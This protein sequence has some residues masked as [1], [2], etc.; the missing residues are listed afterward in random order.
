VQTLRLVGHEGA[1]GGP[2]GERDSGVLATSACLS[3][4]RLLVG[5]SA[6]YQCPGVVV[7]CPTLLAFEDY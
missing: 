6:G 7:G 3:G 2:D 4:D 1:A 5:L